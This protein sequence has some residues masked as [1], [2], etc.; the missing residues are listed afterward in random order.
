MDFKGQRLSEI[1]FSYI[2]IVF[3]AAAF[4]VGYSLESFQLMMAVFTTGLAFSLLVSVP[5]WPMYNRH[6]VKWLPAKKS[7]SRTKTRKSKGWKS[8]LKLF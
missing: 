4:L 8:W 6:P 7:E 2:M 5:D 3:G 1:Y